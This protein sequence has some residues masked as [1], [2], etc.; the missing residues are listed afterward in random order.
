MWYGW[1]TQSELATVEAEAASIGG[2]SS[3]AMAEYRRL[4]QACPK[5]DCEPEPRSTQEPVSTLELIYARVCR[6]AYVLPPKVWV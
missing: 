2:T 1:G 6:R 4:R 3:E 5:T